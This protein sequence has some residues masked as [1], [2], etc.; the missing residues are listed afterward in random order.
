MSVLSVCLFSQRTLSDEQWIEDIDFII[1]R[2]DS[3]HPNPYLYISK[4]QFHS[5]ISNL[6]LKIP[7]YSDNEIIV[8]LLQIITLIR[9]G[10]TRLHGNNL[11]KE[12]YP[13]RIEEFPDGYFITSCSNKYKEAI[14]SEV[15]R[16]NNHPAGNVFEMTKSI[17]PHDNEFS[18]K[19]FSPLLLTMTSVFSGFHINDSSGILKLYT[20][21]IDNQE[22][23]LQIDPVEFKSAD[24]LAWFWRQYGV[25]CES[26]SN[27]ISGNNSVPL[28][29][30]NYDKP[31]W[32]EYLKKDTAVYFA[33][34]E[35][36]GDNG[37]EKFNKDLWECIDSVKAKYLIIDLRNNFGGSNSILQPLIHEII[38]HD[39]IN[40]KGKLFV[41]IGRKT[42]SA[43]MHCATW[44]EYHCNPIFIGEPTG[45]AP[46]HF[47]GPD[48]SIL[49]N[50]GILLMV[51]RYYWQNTWPWDKR[52]YINPLV[53][54]DLTSFDYFNNR[55]PVLERVL[56]MIE[57]K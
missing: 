45:S 19:Y 12:W 53:R 22:I 41:L 10:H 36:L 46:N 5:E 24:D 9:D 11:T 33:F 26:Y 28:Y 34:N 4:D 50:S 7:V 6:K 38:R 42:F 14:G 44:I 23:T 51:S 21:N 3:V 29:L 39:E 13:I 25:P 40:Q 15:I 1:H 2:I 31:F 8:K 30:K 52:A 20:K 54:V 18:Q 57:N 35:C 37:F 49:P 56:N 17:T 32:F 27:I 48:F 43:A 16:I 55:D 47:A